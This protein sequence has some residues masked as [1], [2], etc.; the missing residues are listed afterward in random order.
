MHAYLSVSVCVWQCETES[1]ERVSTACVCVT[2]KSVCP[3]RTGV[4]PSPGLGAEAVIPVRLPAGGSQQSSISHCWGQ[5]SVSVSLSP[6]GCVCCCCCHC[7]SHRQR[8][9]I[10]L[11]KPSSKSCPCSL[12]LS[13]LHLYSSSY[14]LGP[15]LSPSPL[16]SHL[17]LSASSTPPLDA[18]LLGR[19]TYPLPGSR[20]CGGEVGSEAGGRV[21]VCLSLSRSRLWARA[22]RASLTGL[23]AVQPALPAGR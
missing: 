3:C 6:S 15:P 9:L 7:C 11:E 17:S 5:T 16:L 12:V 14:C 21:S 10:E 19:G 18:Q 2:I 13:S 1:R 23:H 20:C 4:C 8:W 22:G